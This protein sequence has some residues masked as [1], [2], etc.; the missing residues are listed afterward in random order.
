[1]KYRFIY[2]TEGYGKDPC[3]ESS[4]LI[5]SEGHDHGV[6]NTEFLPSQTCYKVH[7]QEV[8]LCSC[9]VV[10]KRPEKTIW[11]T[12]TIKERWNNPVIQANI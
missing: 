6:P 1:M 5:W 11:K 7:K 4:K 10:S 9:Q 8:D 3:C 12:S 2:D